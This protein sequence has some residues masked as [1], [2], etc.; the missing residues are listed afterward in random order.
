MMSDAEF[1]IFFA[2]IVAE[3]FVVAFVIVWWGTRP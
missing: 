1:A 2:E 3:G